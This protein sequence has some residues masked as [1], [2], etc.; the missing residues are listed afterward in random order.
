M[1][2]SPASADI[3][4]E[5]GARVDVGVVGV[6]IIQ[7]FRGSVD[8]LRRLTNLRDYTFWWWV[9]V[10]IVW[11]CGIDVSSGKEREVR[12]SIRTGD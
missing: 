12:G 11:C 3:L 2:I 4:V 10:S 5:I 6:E 8:T 1:A 9:L 7:D